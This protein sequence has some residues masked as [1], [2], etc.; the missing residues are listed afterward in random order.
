MRLTILTRRPPKPLSLVVEVPRR[1]KEHDEI[2]LV[3]LEH[4]DY[5]Y[6]NL[7]IYHNANL[8]WYSH[9][10]QFEPGSEIKISPGPVIVIYHAAFHT[11]RLEIIKARC[12][13]T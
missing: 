5:E 2:Q 9:V 4:I 8:G 6:N 12:W 1:L 3:F 13:S 10:H 7:C 11:L